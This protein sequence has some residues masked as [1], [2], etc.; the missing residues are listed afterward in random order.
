MRTSFLAAAGLLLATPVVAPAAVVTLD[1]SGNICDSTVPNNGPCFQAATS[2]P[3]SQTYG[4]GP[5]IDV[6]YHA[7]SKSDGSTT[8]PYFLWGSDAGDLTAVASPYMSAGNLGEIS[9]APTAGYEVA[10]RSFDIGCFLSTNCPYFEFAVR[11]GGGA[12]VTAGTQQTG[13]AGHSSFLPSTAFFAQ[14]LV[15]QFEPANGIAID[16][17][18][19]E[20]RAI[21]TPP[22]VPEPSTWAMMI[23]GFG[24][25][26]GSLRRRQPTVSMA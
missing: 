16:N 9:F 6:A 13:P 19:F 15:L 23:A 25:I 8:R 10:L 12:L 3:I 21:P 18:V 5:T 4:D 24:L 7:V 11:T 26:G 1:F 17:I 20:V 14:A 2:T 22:P